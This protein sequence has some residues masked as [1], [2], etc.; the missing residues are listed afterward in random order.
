MSSP[1][2]PQQRHWHGYQQT[3]K[4]VTHT[5]ATD[6]PD[7]FCSLYMFF[8]TL[9]EEQLWYRMERDLTCGDCN[10]VFCSAGLLEKHKARFC[11]RTGTRS[12]AGHV[13]V[14]R[15]GSELLMRDRPGCE[16]PKQ[17]RTPDL[18][19]VSESWWSGKGEQSQSGWISWALLWTKLKRELVWSMWR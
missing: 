1:T 7:T 17:T 2:A 4:P 11:V 5:G 13:R 9:D 8:L 16:D 3:L 14:H 18:V 15:H 10:M 6:K 12:E 19:Q